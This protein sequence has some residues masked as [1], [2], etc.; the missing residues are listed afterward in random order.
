MLGAKEMPNPNTPG[1][2][3]SLF[4]REHLNTFLFLYAVAYAVFSK[5]FFWRTKRNLSEYF[6]AALYIL[7]G[8]I[9]VT[10]ISVIGVQFSPY[11]FLVNYLMVIFYPTI[12]TY[13]FHK[14]NWFFRGFR[15]FILSVLTF[16]GY[17]ILGFFISF[18]IV[19]F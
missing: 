19:Q 18:L 17:A 4:F 12:V 3:A 2:K 8:Y 14:G 9:S 5:L 10:S 6:T 13:N 1:T 15:A 7:S 11:A 16:F